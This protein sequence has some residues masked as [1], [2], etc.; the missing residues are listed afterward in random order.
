M[1][2][3]DEIEPGNAQFEAAVALLDSGVP[4]EL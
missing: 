1:H 4:Q 2:I 3:F